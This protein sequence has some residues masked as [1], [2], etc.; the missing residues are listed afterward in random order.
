MNPLMIFLLILSTIE[1]FDLAQGFAS[2][3]IEQC[4]KPM[5]VGTIMMG[6]PTELDTSYH[7]K[8][9]RHDLTEVVNG[10]N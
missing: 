5:E 1:N 2:K 9:Y 7:L 8:L 10:G 4:D 3:L 6:M